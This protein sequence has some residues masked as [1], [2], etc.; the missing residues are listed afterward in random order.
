MRGVVCRVNGNRVVSVYA[1]CQAVHV[2]VKRVGPGAQRGDG[3]VAVAACD[4]T[5]ALE[6]VFAG[7]HIRHSS[8][9][10][11]GRAVLT[12]R[13][14]RAGDRR[15]IVGTGDGDGNGCG[16]TAMNTVTRQRN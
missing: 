3:Q 2:G 10:T 1:R 9:S 8:G 4:G 16:C 6:V 5:A 11:H 7:V 15:H 13:G 14:A 12:N